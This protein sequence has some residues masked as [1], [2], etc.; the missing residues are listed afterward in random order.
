MKIQIKG[1]KLLLLSLIY[2]NNAY[3]KVTFQYKN[4]SFSLE[5][6]DN[7][8]IDRTVILPGRYDKF[9]KK[10]DKQSVFSIKRDSYSYNVNDIWSLD[11]SGFKKELEVGQSIGDFKFTRIK[12]ND[13]HAVKA[14]F[15]L[16]LNVVGTIKNYKCSMYKLLFIENNVE[17]VIHFYLLSDPDEFR[18]SDADILEMIKSINK[19][20]N[21]Q[22][23]FKTFEFNSVKYKIPVVEGYDNLIDTSLISTLNSTELKSLGVVSFEYLMPKANDSD[24]VIHIYSNEIFKDKKIFENDFKQAKEFWKSAYEKQNFK[25]IRNIL[26]RD[27][28]SIF[29]DVFNNSGIDLQLASNIKEDNQLLSTMVIV[30]ESSNSGM[31]KKIFIINYIHLNNTIIFIK[32][33]KSFN[34]YDD[35]INLEQKSQHVLSEFL[36]LNQ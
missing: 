29:N 8:V 33:F 7:W 10:S 18:H 25:I 17:Y 5:I 19:V 36:K 2:F 35:I 11:E 32:L 23:V 24:P 20:D 15:K 13:N 27:S 21:S 28:A 31:G 6:L 16:A 4:P 3:S 14:E 9:I 1:F 12:I 22:S 30:D 34:N 26:K